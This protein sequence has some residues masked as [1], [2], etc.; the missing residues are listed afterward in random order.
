MV[1]LLSLKQVMTDQRGGSVMKK[2]DNSHEDLKLD[3]I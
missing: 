1:P 3:T 2:E